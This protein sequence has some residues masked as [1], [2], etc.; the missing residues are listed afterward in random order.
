[1]TDCKSLKSTLKNPKC[2]KHSDKRLSIEIA[3]LRQDLWRKKGDD[4]G[5]PFYDDYRP[6]NDQLT[7]IVKWIDTDVMIADPLTKVTEPVKLVEALETNVLDIEQPIDS[8]VKKRA[9]QLQRRKGDHD[10]DTLNHE[11]AIT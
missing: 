4:A 9:K 10:A 2:N 5:D 11:T 8:V 1:M 3:S 6:A 7:D